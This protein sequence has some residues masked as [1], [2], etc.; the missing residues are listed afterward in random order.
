MTT[1][2]TAL[3]AD[4]HVR[5]TLAAAEPIAVGVI[6]ALGAA[7]YV[8]VEAG[9][10]N[11][12]AYIDPWIYTGLFL[13]FD[14]IYDAYGY[15]YYASRL[16]WIIPGQ[17][18]N[19]ILS[20]QAA[21]F[22]LHVGFMLAAA[23]ATYLLVRRFLGRPAAFVAYVALLAN[24]LFYNAYV[25]DYPDGAVI[26]YLLAGAYFAL[27]AEGSRRPA[28][29][30]G[31]G[32]FLLAAA[33]ATNL[34]A[35]FFVGGLA[36][37]Y[38]IA[39]RPTG[40]LRA[41]ARDVQ[42]FALGVVALVLTCGIYARANGGDFF[43]FMPSV[44]QLGALENA[45]YKAPDYDWVWVEPRIFLPPFLL[46]ALALLW[47]RDWWRRTR[48]DGALAATVGFAAF[49]VFVLA[50]GVWVQSK[51]ALFE[52][53]YYFSVYVT[54]I[55]L[56]LAGAVH[57]IF[58]VA[59]PRARLAAVAAVATLAAIPTL[60]VFELRVL[61][62]AGHTGV[63]WTAVAMVAALAAVAAL[64][65]P[66]LRAAPRAVV[67]VAAVAALVF[68][69]NLAAATSNTAYGAFA[70]DSSTYETRSSTLTLAERFVE[71]MKRHRLQDEQPWFWYDL[72]KNP[73]ASALN[74]LYLWGYTAVGFEMPKVDARLREV[75]RLH[76]P[77]RLILLCNDVTC[78]G[79][80]AALRRNGF[81]LEEQTR[82]LLADDPVR[83]WVRV[84]RLPKFHDD[85]YA[86]YY[87]PRQ[88]T[89]TRDRR[90]TRLRTWSFAEGLPRG[91]RRL[92]PL[93]LTRTP[94]GVA[95]ETSPGPTDYELGTA[96]F[97]LPPGTYRVLADGAVT[98]GG[99]AI[100]VLDAETKTWVTQGRYWFRQRGFGR[101]AMAAEFTLPKAQRVS[102]LLTNF[103]PSR[104]KS[105][106]TIRE[107]HLV[108]VKS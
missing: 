100:G 51:G 8:W 48:E 17:I 4:V 23:L 60:L 24:L 28:L 68:A 74:S 6:A 35:G 49:F 45:S 54:G 27:T 56:V 9:V 67:A 72:A 96:V 108:R 89:F 15:T 65:L 57:V 99:L 79:G 70:T 62:L 95:V 61:V 38:L 14:F 2:R 85:A 50:A 55:I 104:L 42:S 41:L 39:H 101:A 69:T 93:A 94:R 77:E 90:G 5:P 22:V 98:R 31:L 19:S 46:L 10:F 12:P 21:F 37:A 44:D 16:P 102:I 76:R 58:R 43:F 83:V 32:G 107:I 66:I 82:T 1:A 52:I 30:M 47:Q 59:P 33:V 26:A 87:L 64:R 103:A 81:P 25:N 18:L 92:S 13:N 75:L 106:W 3:R 34:F 71:F 78:E 29:R 86:E 73:T 97:Q 63:R 20:P 53:P 84:F 105:R 88:S 7:F 80:P 36:V 11:N 91:W 40:A